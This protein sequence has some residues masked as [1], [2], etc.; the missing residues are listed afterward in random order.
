VPQHLDPAIKL[1]ISSSSNLPRHVRTEITT[2]LAAT[3]AQARISPTAA[4]RE[5]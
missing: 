4:K 5:L 2:I 1:L 3:A